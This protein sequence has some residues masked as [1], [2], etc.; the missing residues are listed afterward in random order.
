MFPRQTFRACVASIVL[1]WGT[2]RQPPRFQSSLRPKLRRVLPRKRSSVGNSPAKRSRASGA[3]HARLRGPAASGENLGVPLE[4]RR[5]ACG[6]EHAKRAADFARLVAGLHELSALCDAKSNASA[7]VHAAR[8]CAQ[9]TP[10][11]V[12]QGILSDKSRANADSS[13]ATAG[14]VAS[15]ARR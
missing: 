11:I 5:A 15:P 2:W 13:A 12:L 3:A 1:R 10:S 4:R 8:P 9:R 7:T 14:R 6:R